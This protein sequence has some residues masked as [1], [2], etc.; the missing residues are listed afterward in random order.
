MASVI[1]RPPAPA[2][3]IVAASCART[4]LQ[5]RSRLLR[6]RRL[7]T[8]WPFL[9]TAP[10]YNEEDNFPVC[11]GLQRH[12]RLARPPSRLVHVSALA[13]KAV[14]DSLSVPAYNATVD[15]PVYTGLPRR[16]RFT[17]VLMQDNCSLRQND[18]VNSL[19]RAG[20]QRHGRIICLSRL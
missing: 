16:G 1:H 11:T 14:A 6:P 12:R 10:V 7:T 18:V 4:G 5:H 20:L 17:L 13:Y 19:I 2:Y 8:P 3:T 9:A 15:S